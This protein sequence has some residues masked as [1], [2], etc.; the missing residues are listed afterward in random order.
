MATWKLYEIDDLLRQA[1]DAAD[2]EINQ[3]TGEIPEGWGEFLDAVQ[4]DRDHKVLSVACYIKELDAEAAALKSER[5]RLAERQRAT[6]AKAERIR[7][8]LSAHVQPGEKLS[9][10]R[11]VISWRKSD[12][13]DVQ[14]DAG[15][16]PTQY[17]REIPARVE[18]DKV[19]LKAALKAGE[20]VPGCVLVTKQNI[21]IK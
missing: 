5:D 19:A 10:A 18:P 13:V 16:L 12:S 20:A 6:E 9:D 8:Y 4:L 1:I 2:A 7:E 11:A 21:Q 3:E 15:M 17:V 14:V